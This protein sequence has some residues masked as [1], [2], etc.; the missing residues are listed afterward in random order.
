MSTIRCQSIFG[1]FVDIPREKLTFRPSVY[2]LIVQA[3][4]SLMLINACNGKYT[5]P[6]GGVEIGETLEQALR[7]EM[8]E[9]TG[10]SIEIGPLLTVR[11]SFFYYDP[12]NLAFHGFL[13]YYTCQATS[14]VIA[15]HQSEFDESEHPGW[16]DL[17]TLSRD[18]IQP[19]NEE[20]FDLLM[21]SLH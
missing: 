10:L 7:R 17:A 20:I 19:G 13:F 16:V 14:Q 4:K 11:E 1:N 18:Q 6:G 2:A 8:Y 3:G 12:A 21:K 9:E 15:P 5:F